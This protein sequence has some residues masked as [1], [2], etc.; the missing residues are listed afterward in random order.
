M[1]DGAE[2]DPAAGVADDVVAVW[3]DVVLGLAEP[4]VD[5]R[6]TLA[7][8]PPSPA[9]ITAVMTSRRTRPELLDPIRL[10]QGL[11]P[12]SRGWHRTSSGLRSLPNSLQ[13]RPARQPS[14]HSQRTLSA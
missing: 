3:V 5:A 12:L 4:P 9:A 11:T 10:L 13:T 7:T 6:A 14:P 1:L 8:P 2:L